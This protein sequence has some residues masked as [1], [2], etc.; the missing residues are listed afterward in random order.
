VIF[1]ACCLDLPAQAQPEQ[2]EEQEQRRTGVLEEV[3]VSA[4]R[5]DQNLQTVPIAVTAFTEESLDNA[6][7]ISTADISQVTPGLVWVTGRVASSMYLRGVGT[8]EHHMGNE[9][10]VATYVDGIYY[11]DL[12]AGTISL[13][14]VER[15]ELLR[16]PQGTLFGRNAVG[17]LLNIITKTPSHDTRGSIEAGYGNYDTYEGK[18]YGTTGLSESLA[19]DF[20]MYFHDQSGNWGTN[21]ATGEDVNTIEEILS[22]RSKW[23]L[24]IGADTSFTFAVDYIER[25]TD[26]GSHRHFHPESTGGVDGTPFSGS[27]HNTS[28]DKTTEQLT[29][30]SEQWG[31]SLTIEHNF[32]PAQFR[33]MTAYRHVDAE[34]AFDADN[35]P[36]DLFFLDFPEQESEHVTQE[37][38]LLS[39]EASSFDWIVGLFYMD[40]QAD[41]NPLMLSGA[42]FPP[43]G[44]NFF[45]RWDTESIAGFAQTTFGLPFWRDTHLTLGGRYTEDTQKFS[46]DLFLAGPGIPIASADDKETF[47]KAT[48]RVVLDHQFNDSIMGYVSYDRGFKSGTYNLV[49][50]TA[51]PIK[52]EVLDAFEVTAVRLNERANR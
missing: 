4:Q 44:L 48:W 52:P 24:E 20:S 11:P 33:S 17:G 7:I 8:T 6:S 1:L 16:G 19:A 28:S 14:N 9:S 13:D 25:E 36:S 21:V 27:I 10:P 3:I 5:R 51:T 15:V 50:T 39:P 31:V 30:L 26:L 42:A 34:L 18:F 32:G 12:N 47:S 40:R 23:L 49:D 35:S 38:H 37:F 46:I 22:L 45:D 43:G 29:G 41:Y 2:A